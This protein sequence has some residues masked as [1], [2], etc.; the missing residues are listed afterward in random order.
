[1]EEGNRIEK[2]LAMLLINSLT[3]KNMAEKAV[4]LST[5]GF[6]NVE[7]ANLLHTNSGSINQLLYEVRKKGKSRGK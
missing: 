4:Q 6:T 2:L 7:I 1:M 5:V 3:G